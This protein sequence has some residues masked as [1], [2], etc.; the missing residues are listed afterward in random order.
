MTC[1]T[2]KMSALCFDVY[3]ALVLVRLLI[4]HTHTHEERGIVS[5]C[6]CE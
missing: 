4:T 2:E 6:V 3:G 1:V 5:E